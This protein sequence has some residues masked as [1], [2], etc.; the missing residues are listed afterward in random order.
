MAKKI[1]LSGI[2]EF[3]FNHGE[4]VA[5]GACAFLG[6]ILG[7]WGVWAA[8]G[9]GRYPG[10]SKSYAEVFKE[11]TSQVQAGLNQ[12]VA[13]DENSSKAPPK[14]PG[15]D[16]PPLKSNHQGTQYVAIPDLNN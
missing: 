13:A 15:V 5:L 4:K 8:S 11:R 6:V 1:N 12:Q 14:I 16:W 2:K 10:S 9:A 3:L 7:L